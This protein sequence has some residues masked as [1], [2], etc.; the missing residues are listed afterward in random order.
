MARNYTQGVYKPQNPNKYVGDVANIIY[1]SSWELR[2]F[3]W[4]DVNDSVLAWQ[5]EE[6]IIPYLCETDNKMHRYFLDV[7]LKIKDRN[8][9]IG[10]F[11]VEIKPY[12]QTIPPKYPGKQTKRYLQEVETFVK[13][14]SKWKAAK[15]Y[16][17]QRNMKFLVLTEKELFGHK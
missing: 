12:A 2:F 16:A 4:C 13:N 10:I 5:S 17:E 15:A 8:G 7:K 1:R 9:K 6:T 11:L 3:Q 14:Q